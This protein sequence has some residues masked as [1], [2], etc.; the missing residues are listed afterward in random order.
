MRAI[1]F[2]DEAIYL[3]SFVAR[4]CC[5][6][7]DK[8]EIDFLWTPQWRVIGI[9]VYTVSVT[10]DATVHSL[11]KGEEAFDIMKAWERNVVD[12]I[13]RGKSDAIGLTRNMKKTY[14]Q[15]IYLHTNTIKKVRDINHNSNVDNDDKRHLSQNSMEYSS[16]N[17]QELHNEDVQFNRDINIDDENGDDRGLSQDDSIQDSKSND[18]DSE[19]GSISQ[20]DNEYNS[21]NNKESNDEDIPLPLGPLDIPILDTSRSHNEDMQITSEPLDST[22]LETSKYYKD[23]MQLQMCS[24][25]LEASISK[26]SRINDE[27]TPNLEISNVGFVSPQEYVN[28]IPTFEV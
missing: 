19:R 10:I 27:D 20:D 14:S 21:S 6:Y 17:Y 3:C 8:K 16:K 18:D 11:V 28:G 4:V 5:L 7:R 12:E 24:G 1:H 9:Y 25:S 22:I 2:T 26:P 23:D 15:D 13:G